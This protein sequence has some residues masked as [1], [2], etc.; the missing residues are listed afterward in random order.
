MVANSWV[1]M[2]RQRATARRR[3]RYRNTG[4]REWRIMRGGRG[5]EEMVSGEGAAGSREGGGLVAKGEAENTVVSLSTS[6]SLYSPVRSLARSPA[7]S[8]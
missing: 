1:K 7:A 4:V 6:N 5:E 2:P 3:T 8:S